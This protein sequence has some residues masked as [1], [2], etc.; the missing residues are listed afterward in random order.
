MLENHLYSLPISTERITKFSERH[1]S[2]TKAIAMLKEPMSNEQI[3]LIKEQIPRF[4]A[5]YPDLNPAI[6][7]QELRIVPTD[8]M[9]QFIQY[10]D[11]A[12]PTW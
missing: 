10:V 12:L 2:K 9:T 1:P 6:I 5:R 7:I 4:I 3:K 11:E 8:K